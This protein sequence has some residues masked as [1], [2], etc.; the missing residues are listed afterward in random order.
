MRIVLDTNILLRRIERSHPMHEIV[1]E[2]IVTL[3]KR[4]CSFFVFLQNVSE[5]W[6]VCTRPA[7]NNGLGL[8]IS[9]TDQ[10]LS[11]FEQLFS[12]LPDNELVFK[13]WR[14][15]V[16]KYSVTGVRVH[17][18]K[19]VAAMMA[20]GINELLTFNISDFNRFDGITAV[21]PGDI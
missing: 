5:F 12:V 2:S 15:L 9:E 3:R 6:N 18:A 11:R 19:I 14:K 8:S 13:Y 21:V 16:V 20:H 10:H 4:D 17:D 1:N 7:E